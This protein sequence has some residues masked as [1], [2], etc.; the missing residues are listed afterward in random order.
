MRIGRT[1][2]TTCLGLVLA[3]QPAAGAAQIA[4]AWPEEAEDR[5]YWVSEGNKASLI[6]LDEERIL[7]RQL[8]SRIARA[9]LEVERAASA[10]GAARSGNYLVIERDLIALAGPD[11]SRLH[12]GRS[13]QDLGATARRA[14]M[15]EEFLAAYDRF[16]AARASLLNLARSHPDAVLPFYTHA[17]QAQPITL[18]HYLG[19]YLQ[20]LDRQSDRYREIYARLN[21]SPFGSAVGATSSFPLNRPRLAELMAFDGVIVNSFDAGQISLQDMG[22]DIAGASAAGTLVVSM[23][24]ADLLTQ[25][26]NP[27]PWFQ[28]RE[29]DQT[30]SSSIMPQKRNPS[31]LEELQEASGLVTGLATTYLMLAQNIPSGLDSYK[32]TPIPLNILSNSRVAYDRMSKM[33]DALEFHPARALERVNEDY[34]V[35]TELADVLQ[36]EADIPFRVGHHFASELVNHGRA[37]RLRPMQLPYDEARRLFTAS[38]RQFGIAQTTLPLTERRFRETL[39]AENM[40]RS[41]RPLGGPQPAEVARMLALA[42]ERLA[43]DRTWLAARN[44]QIEQA[45][46]TRAALIAHIAGAAAE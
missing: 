5:F 24:M 18:G 11:A 42:E 10:P 38:A 43:Q 26:G 33:L 44:R 34:S 14:E 36:R 20:A 2:A 29:G 6:M 35:M 4:P 28:L 40:V 23:L 9:L 22:T 13:R 30:G 3:L 21:I 37:N 8:T 32:K 45:A 15:R 17:V 27:F 19:G 16:I 31:A 39:S 41:A 7:P 1:I 25:Y 12:T 46:Q